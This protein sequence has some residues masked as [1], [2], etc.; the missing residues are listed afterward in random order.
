MHIQSTDKSG[1]RRAKFTLCTRL[2]KGVGGGGGWF[3]ERDTKKNFNWIDITDMRSWRDDRSA[4]IYMYTH[5][6]IYMRNE[7]PGIYVYTQLGRAQ[8]LI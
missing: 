7:F 3:G 1:S 2:K 8:R 5:I 4:C 6:Y